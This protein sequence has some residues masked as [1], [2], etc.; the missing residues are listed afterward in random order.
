[1]VFSHFTCHI[2]FM[3]APLPGKFGVWCNLHG[4]ITMGCDTSFFFWQQASTEARIKSFFLVYNYVD[5]LYYWFLCLYL[6]L[7]TG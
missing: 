2:G 6:L 1:M 3:I 5:L 4:H 7:A